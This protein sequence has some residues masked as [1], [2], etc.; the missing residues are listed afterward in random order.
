MS[1][2]SLQR[3]AALRRLK[4]G[5]L[6]LALFVAVSTVGYMVLGWLVCG[7]D[8]GFLD[9]LFMTI[10]TVT[11]IGYGDVLG[12][13][14]AG[15]VSAMVYTMVVSLVG[16]GAALY[17][18]SMATAF[19]VEGDLHRVLWRRKMSKLIEKMNGHFIVCGIGSTGLHVVAELHAT[20]RPFV[21]IDSSE[22]GVQRLQRLL[23]DEVV[24]I[25]GDATDDE[26]LRAAGVERAGG[27]VAALHSDPQ[28]LFLTISARRLNPTMRIIARGIDS[29]TSAKLRQAGADS[30][31][32]PNLIGG[33]RMVS[34][35]IRPETVSFLDVMLRDRDTRFRFEDLPIEPGSTAE[36]KSLGD[37]KLRDRFGVV[38]VAFRES[39]TAP[40][41][42]C[43][44]DGQPLAGGNRLV[45]LGNA[46]R[47]VEAKG[48]VA[49]A[50]AS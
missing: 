24:V 44:P 49:I 17:V 21:A 7:E 36:G 48:A 25:I 11:T 26:V 16:M 39:P 40:L 29:N 8:W 33:L 34:E 45:V 19:V 6:F 32:S 9:S 15:H 10:I 28:N 37:L 2:V 14:E 1:T 20:G 5:L 47:V 41:V 3:I 12:V 38:V 30:V 50:R 18:V 46:D 31:V 13:Q 42:Y 27:L 22:E 23:G 43:P 35:M 4:L